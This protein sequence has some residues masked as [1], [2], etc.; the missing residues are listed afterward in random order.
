MD[1][2]SLAEGFKLPK[3]LHQVWQ[4]KGKL[5]LQVVIFS[6]L[7]RSY[8]ISEFT[9]SMIMADYS[10]WECVLSTGWL[11]EIDIH[12][13]GILSLDI[14]ESWQQVIRLFMCKDVSWSDW[15]LCESNL[16]G[17]VPQKINS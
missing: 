9:I 2:L 16:W 6:V 4:W 1:Y 5:L 10:W 12:S 17:I 11:P 15:N 3:C 13:E 14:K 7:S 8:N